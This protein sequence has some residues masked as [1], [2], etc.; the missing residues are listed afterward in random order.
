MEDYA[1][2]SGLF[3]AAFIAATVFPAQSEALLVG[4]V[5]AGGQPVWLLVAVA[6]LGNVLGAVVNWGLG[7]AI[8]RFR[9]ARW[10]PASEKAL[11]RAER[12]YHRWGRWSL[13]LSWLPFF[14]DALTVIAGVLREPLWSFVALVSIGKV[15]RYVVL[16][17][18]TLAAR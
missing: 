15:G 13:L 10:F 6:S 1:V 2:Y 12:F 8:E 5:I 18:V 16:A 17:W 14:G 11:G 3:L 9:H 4:L 7:R